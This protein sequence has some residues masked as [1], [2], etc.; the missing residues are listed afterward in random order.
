MMQRPYHDLKP[1]DALVAGAEGPPGQRVFY[2]QGRK[3]S[4][5]VTLRMEKEQV[6]LLATSIA[7]L[8]QDIEDLP[9]PDPASVPVAELEH[10]LEPL[11]SV[12]QMGLGYEKSE[13]L[14]ALFMQGMRPP[15]AE[16]EF[17]DDE[18]EDDEAR[19][20]LVRFWADSSQLQAFSDRALVVV[21]AGRPECP[22]CHEPIDPDGHLCPRSNG[23]A[24]PIV[25]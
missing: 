7:N 22:L 20:M 3:D 4:L 25:L 21:E 16:E 6:A 9:E 24:D 12:T 18:E 11:F 8:L 2:M 17:V 5:L 19:L 15:D 23:H 13:E 14:F 10:P 1:V